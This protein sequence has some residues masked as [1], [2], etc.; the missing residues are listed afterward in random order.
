M[1]AAW[2]LTIATASG[3]L[4]FVAGVLADE[5]AGRVKARRLAAPARRYR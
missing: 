5:V 3:C 2:W 1:T 4:G